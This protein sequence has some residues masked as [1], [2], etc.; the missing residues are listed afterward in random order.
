MEDASLVK[1]GSKQNVK[2]EQQLMMMG[3][4]FVGGNNLEE[5]EEEEPELE[6]GMP[7]IEKNTL[8]EELMS[9]MS[10]KENSGSVN[11]TGVKSGTVPMLPQVQ[12]KNEPVCFST[13]AFKKDPS[14]PEI[15]CEVILY[16]DNREKKNQ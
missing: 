5:E 7:E 6:S 11:I 3:D 2:I 14:Y 15:E 9:M 13:K 1:K 8:A 16:V 10:D 4:V 12:V